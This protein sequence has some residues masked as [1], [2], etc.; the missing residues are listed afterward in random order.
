MDE[1]IA[2]EIAG[3]KRRGDEI[4]DR[5]SA[6]KIS[7]DEAYRLLGTVIRSLE[8]KVVWLRSPEI[9]ELYRALAYLEMI[10]A[11]IRWTVRDVTRALGG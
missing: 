8:E 2:R 9:R 7:P 11:D 10:G 3:A 4:W 5:V 6:G 1:R